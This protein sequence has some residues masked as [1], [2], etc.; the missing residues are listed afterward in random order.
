MIALLRE[1][2]KPMSLRQCVWKEAASFGQV[3]DPK[4]N[5]FWILFGYDPLMHTF[6][7]LPPVYGISP[8]NG[9]DQ[10]KAGATEFLEAIQSVNYHAW[11]PDNQAKWHGLVLFVQCLKA[12]GLPCSSLVAWAAIAG[13]DFSPLSVSDNLGEVQWAV[14][15]L[16]SADQLLQVGQDGLAALWHFVREAKLVHMKVVVPS[17]S[18]DMLMLY[19]PVDKSAANHHLWDYVKASCQLGAKLEK[20]ESLEG[21]VPFYNSKSIMK[22]GNFE[23]LTSV[24]SVSSVLLRNPEVLLAADAMRTSRMTFLA[25]A[26]L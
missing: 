4:L 22:D 3:T 24:E 9:S 15:R 19:T 26:R 21:V 23:L 18:L 2:K 20:L 11:L 13:L 8:L 14:P 17:P 7:G 12:G 16:Q 6:Y 1:T 5:P 25:Q 10:V